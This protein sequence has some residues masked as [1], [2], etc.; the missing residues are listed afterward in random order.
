MCNF[1][2]KFAVDFNMREYARSYR[3][4]GALQNADATGRL[5]AYRIASILAQLAEL[6]KLGIGRTGKALQDC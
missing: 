1:C 5:E 3:T 2:C 6:D 4:G